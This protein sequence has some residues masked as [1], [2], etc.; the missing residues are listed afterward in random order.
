MVRTAGGQLDTPART[1]NDGRQRTE[2]EEE[3]ATKPYPSQG[4]TI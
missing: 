2:E 3:H 4:T 1:A